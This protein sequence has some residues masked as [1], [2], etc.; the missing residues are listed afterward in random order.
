MMLTINYGEKIHMNTFGKVTVS[1]IHF[2][3][4]CWFTDQ[5]IDSTIQLIYCL[6]KDV[7]NLYFTS[8]I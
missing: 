4:P 5:V 3:L 1:N 6:S 2:L 8:V 7:M